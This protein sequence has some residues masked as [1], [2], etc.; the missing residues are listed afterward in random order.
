MVVVGAE[1]GHGCHCDAIGELDAA[2]AERGE[3]FGHFDFDLLVYMNVF[4]WFMGVLGY[5]WSE[6]P[7]LL[8][9]FVV[10]AFVENFGAPLGLTSSGVKMDIRDYPA[11]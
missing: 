5:I 2:D 8:Y 7:W 10:S 11:F 9:I 1:A 3:E 6:W 4:N